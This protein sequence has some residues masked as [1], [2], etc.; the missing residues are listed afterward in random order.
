MESYVGNLKNDRLQN[1][2]F[3]NSAVHNL[4]NCPELRDY[5]MN[6]SSQELKKKASVESIA[7]NIQ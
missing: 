1:D 3:C 2:C 5:I 6:L 4:A 7:E